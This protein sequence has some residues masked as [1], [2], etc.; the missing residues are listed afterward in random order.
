LWQSK[1]NLES[2]PSPKNCAYQKMETN[3]E[4]F[5]RGPHFG[6]HGR[7]APFL[8]PL[9]E[10]WGFSIRTTFTEECEGHLNKYILGA[11]EK[12]NKNTTQSFDFMWKQTTIHTI[13]NVCEKIKITITIHNLQNSQ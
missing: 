4:C 5:S 13:T 1:K 9:R 3:F 2:N 8:G 6:E 10:G 7:E 11:G 12:Y